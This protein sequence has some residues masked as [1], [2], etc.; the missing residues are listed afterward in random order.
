MDINMPCKDGIQAT[1][2]IRAIE[3]LENLPKCNICA[4]TSWTDVQT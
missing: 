4:Y 2:E 1:S 3:K